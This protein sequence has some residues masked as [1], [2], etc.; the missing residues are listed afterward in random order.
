MAK[1]STT[2]TLYGGGKTDRRY[3]GP[4]LP[5][6]ARKTAHRRAIRII[7]LPQWTDLRGGGGI[8]KFDA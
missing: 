1:K 2:E 6:A 3:S 8:L 4:S 5:V 7:H